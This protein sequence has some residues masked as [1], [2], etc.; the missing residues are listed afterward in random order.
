MPRT[1]PQITADLTREQQRLA[2]IE[3]ARQESRIRLDALQNELAAVSG[4]GNATEPS[5][6]APAPLTPTEKVQLFRALFRGRPDVYPARFVSRKTRQPGYAPACST[7]WRPGQCALLRGGKCGDCDNQAFMPVSDQV[8]LDHLQGRHVMGVYPL[9][10]DETCWLLVV[11]FDKRTWREDVSAFAD[12]CSQ[13][14]LPV[15]IERSRSGRGAHAWF[16]FSAP[17]EASMAR[18]MG[19]HLITETMS[20]RHE[21]AMSSYDRLFPNQ[22]TLP[23]GG[24]G[25]LIALPLQHEPRQQGNSVFVDVQLQPYPDQWAFL[26]SIERIDAETVA[27]IA[28]DAARSA[29]VVAARGTDS[30]DDEVTAAPWDQPPSGRQ[31]RTALTGIALPDTVKAV[32]AQRLLIDKAGLPSP[33]LSQLKRLAAFQNP[34]FYK[35][36]ACACR[37]PWCRASSPAPR[38]CRNIWPC[39]AAAWPTR[40][41]CSPS[42]GS[43]WRSTINART[44]RRWTIRFT[45]R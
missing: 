39:R 1:K 32:L 31:P 21:I 43:I 2:D 23:R 15:A 28:R 14:A 40:G 37:L 25:N 30:G 24:F 38:I 5:S 20:R 42:T 22:D 41:R 17:V 6:S 8:V 12:T 11:D 26:A 7:K 18:A 44:A 19:C 45:A 35:S 16:F 13:A 10:E 36:N 29:R 9:L 33:L 4:R 3:R 34:E 27:A